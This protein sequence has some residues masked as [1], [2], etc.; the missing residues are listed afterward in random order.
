M[1]QS[2][3]AAA[4][5]ARRL[6]LLS[7]K[8]ESGGRGPGTV[9]G[10][11]GDPGG[12]SYGLYQLASRTGTVAAFLGAE[13]R[14]W[15]AD[16]RDSPGSA[17]FS[18]AW[19]AI[20]ARE[21][22]AFAEAQHA[23]IERTHYRPAISAV[24]SA[25]GLDLNRCADAVRDAVWSTAVQHG[26]APRILAAAVADADAR[27]PRGTPAHERAYI[28]AIYARRTA[29]VLALAAKSGP[30]VRRTLT[31]VARRRY[32]DELAAALAMLG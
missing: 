13:G 14:A 11:Q 8:Y 28:E 26:S 25:T 1:D 16:L 18:Q 29:H 22:E 24:R 4:A 17:A 3:L 2:S 15:A 32:P 31:S 9:S 10:G 20:A 5:P 23:F 7:E 6:G 19:K 27:A 30:A 21:G 12:V